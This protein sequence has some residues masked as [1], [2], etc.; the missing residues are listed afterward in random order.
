MRGGND[1]VGPVAIA[2]HCIH[3]VQYVYLWLVALS[4][5]EKKTEMYVAHEPNDICDPHPP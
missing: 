1:E 3:W 2:S 5:G 4:V